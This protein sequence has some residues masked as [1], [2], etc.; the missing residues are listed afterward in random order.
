MEQLGSR[1]FVRDQAS[2]IFYDEH[3]LHVLDHHGK[4]NVRAGQLEPWRD[5]ITELAELPNVVCKVSG[6]VTEADHA[7]W[8]VADLKP[9]VLH[10]LD[11]F[12]E[13]RVLFGGDWPVVTMA[14]SY[15]QWVTSLDQLTSHLSSSARRKLWADNARRVYR[16]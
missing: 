14:A 13:D 10:V 8:T 11:A 6:L 3:K 5:Q 9:Y 1:C 7:H 4:P 15:G 2:G 16:L 12:G